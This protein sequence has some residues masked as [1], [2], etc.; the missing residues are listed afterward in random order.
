MYQGS[1]GNTWGCIWT[2]IIYTIYRIIHL[3]IY[4]SI[5]LFLHSFFHSFIHSFIHG[6]MYLFFHFLSFIT[7]SL[8]Y[9]FSSSRL[10]SK[11]IPILWILSTGRTSIFSN[12]PGSCGHGTIFGTTCLGWCSCGLDLRGMSSLCPS[13]RNGELGFFW[14]KP[15]WDFIMATSQPGPTPLTYRS[16]EK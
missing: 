7:H 11:L 5:N 12:W 9:I 13:E 4:L 2:H 10:A 15:M 3:F 14:E 6:F 8:I 16:P 1:L